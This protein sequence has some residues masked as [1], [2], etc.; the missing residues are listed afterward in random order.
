MSVFVQLIYEVKGGQLVNNDEKSLEG[1]DL[2]AQI[3]LEI[4]NHLQENNMPIE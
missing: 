2:I 4:K 3:G 1:A